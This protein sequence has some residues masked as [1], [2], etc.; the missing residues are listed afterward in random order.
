MDGRGT[1][2][3]TRRLRW[4]GEGGGRG[5]GGEGG[6]GGATGNVEEGEKK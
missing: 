3:G 2:G 5:T 1:G 6:R 4:K